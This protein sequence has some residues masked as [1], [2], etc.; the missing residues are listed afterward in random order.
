MSKGRDRRSPEVEEKAVPAPG[1]TPGAG[2]SLSNRAVAQLLA[3][4]AAPDDPHV[5]AARGRTA[6]TL[7]REA[8][9]KFRAAVDAVDPAAAFEQARVLVALLQGARADLGQA[10]ATMPFDMVSAYQADLDEQALTQLVATAAAEL[11]PRAF[12]GTVITAEP[13]PAEKQTVEGA[14][15][16]AAITLELL[17]TLT[18]IRELVAG[19]RLPDAANLVEGWRGRPVNFLFLF[20]AL[21][22]TELLAP[23]AIFDGV[24]SHRNVFQLKAAVEKSAKTFGMLLDTGTFDLSQAMTSLA[25]YWDDWAITDEEGRKVFEMWASAAPDARLAIL[26]KLESAG[27]LER[28][29]DNANG[30]SI[31]AMFETARRKP[32]SPAYQRLLAAMNDRPQG[33]T[34]SELYEEQIMDHI[35][36]GNYVRGYLWTVLDTA[37]SGVTFGFK[38]I[39]DNAYE[40][41]REGLITSD[42]YWSTTTKAAG[43]AAVVMAAT[44]MTGGAAGGLAEGFA[45]GRGVGQTLAG[46]VGGTAGGTA[47]GLAGQLTADVYDQ[48]LLGKEGFSSAG[49]YLMAGGAGAA[50]GLLTAG[51]GAVGAR[52]APASAEATFQYHAGSGRYRVLQDFRQGLHKM[53]YETYRVSVRAGRGGGRTPNADLIDPQR[54]EHILRGESERQ[55]GHAW[56]PNPRGGPGGGPKSSFPRTW[57]DDHIIDVVTEAATNPQTLWVRQDGPGTGQ[58]F[59]GLPDALV[60]TAAGTP[61]RYRAEVVVDG[62]TIRIIV[63]PHGQ[64]MITAFPSGYQDPA[65]LFMFLNPD[66]ADAH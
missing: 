8:L 47:A 66:V 55:G 32:S 17:A 22:K 28:L 31:E 60:T 62:I 48:A 54:L 49:D 10:A 52:V 56:P 27:R 23:I 58:Q 33:T 37:H 24:V 2:P 9:P 13:V 3:E 51:V 19:S 25:Y 65:N 43:R 53:L 36:E 5:L 21:E 29:C 35:E 11:G 45:L 7:A 46:L 39:H 38:D 57:N 63:Q 44:M 12:R 59:V 61:V 18:Q 50:G 1:R 14:A 6:V 40:Q 26:E 42:E 34:V 41:M 20:H 16:E 4:P 15:A 30:L 64:G